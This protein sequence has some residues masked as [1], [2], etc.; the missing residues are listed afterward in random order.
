MRRTRSA[1][2]NQTIAAHV[3]EDGIVLQNGRVDAIVKRR[4]AHRLAILP[5]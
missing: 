3:P 4:L 2:G 1:I 5:G